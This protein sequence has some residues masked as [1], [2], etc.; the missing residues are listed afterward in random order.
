VARTKDKV[1]VEMVVAV[2]EMAVVIHIHPT[3]S[4][5]LC[6]RGKVEDIMVEVLEATPRKAQ[7]QDRINKAMD[8]WGR[9]DTGVQVQVQVDILP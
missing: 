2:G 6:L 9:M 3:L 4:T 1:K 5:D 8:T 7:C